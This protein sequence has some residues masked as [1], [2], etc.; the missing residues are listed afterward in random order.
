[1]V[2]WLKRFAAPVA[3]VALFAAAPV[4]ASADSITTSSTGAFTAAGTDHVVLG[5]LNTQSNNTSLSYAG[6]ADF[7]ADAEKVITLGEFTLSTLLGPTV[8]GEKFNSN[9]KFT[10]TI[11]QVVTPPG[12]ASSDTSSGKLTTTGTIHAGSG[13]VLILT[14]NPNPVTIDG[15][16]YTLLSTTISGP[17]GVG[18]AG[19]GHGMLQADLVN[20]T[21]TAVPLPSTAWM[22]LGLLGCV[23]SA[24]AFKS[25]RRRRDVL[26]A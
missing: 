4:V 8:A 16:E 25:M 13:G 17:T 14:F 24:G 20:P 26:S 2:S 3:A 21:A 22:G 18:L 1:M 12:T 11:N 23:G 15:K 19:A 10:V 9:D 7:S 6:T 5:S